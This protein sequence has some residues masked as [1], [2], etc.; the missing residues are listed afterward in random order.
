MR[1][2]WMGWTLGLT[3]IGCQV[4]AAVEGSTEAVQ[5]YV[6]QAPVREVISGLARLSQHN[7][8]MGDDVQGKVSLQVSGVTADQALD[9]VATACNLQVI[10]H[11]GT[12]IINGRSKT[13]AESHTAISIPLRYAKAADMQRSL[14]ALLPEEHIR[15]NEAAN[16]VV[17]RGN[18]REIT[19][20]RQ[21]VSRLDYAYQQVK[22]EVEVVAVNRDHLKEL[23]IDWDWM[24]LTGKA[25][26]TRNHY[27][28]R[29][30]RRDKNGQIIYD[31]DGNPKMTTR[32]ISAW[33]VDSPKGY[34]AI[35][36]GRALDGHPYSFF[37]QAK[38]NAL[39]A[40]GKAEILAKP[41]IM[42]TNG[43]EARILIGNKIPVLV[44]KTVNG[45]STTTT[46]YRDAGIQLLY[47]PRINEHNEITADI[48]AEVSSPYLVPEMRAYRIVTREANTRVRLQ[49]GETLTIGGLIDRE[50]M[51]TK[52]KVPFL[53]DIPLLG[54]LF[55]SDK[56]SVSEA[57]IVI[58]IRA[59]VVE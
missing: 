5:L 1:R 7:L 27:T 29:T 24:S 6:T 47:T 54:K 52:R 4:Q 21:L 49:A 57:E 13:D 41:N 14:Q 28:E 43:H 22:V 53:G 38:L 40:D 30:Y 17:V 31:A 44:E 23:G 3:L 35:Q 8:V 55:Q 45:E 51:H 25:D 12:W 2:K 56:R 10:D 48:H 9:M 16:A 34:G 46:E 32:E 33:Q 20:A 50:V 11:Q 39:V 15:I 26:Y 59:E 42:T 37:F 19:L 18:P 36:F 58:L